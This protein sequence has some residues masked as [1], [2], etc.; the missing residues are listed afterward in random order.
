MQAT[1]DKVLKDI[2]DCFAVSGGEEY[3]ID[4]SHYLRAAI[5]LIRKRVKELQP[6]ET[7]RVYA[8]EIITR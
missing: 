8:V 1:R 5:S 4:V 3:Y 2:E 6:D 7:A